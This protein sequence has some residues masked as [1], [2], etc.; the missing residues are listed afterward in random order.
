[1]T[2][3]HHPLYAQEFDLV[4]RGQ[5]W[6]EDRAWFHDRTGRLRS[7]PAT[8]TDLVAE[9]PFNVV[10]D[11]RVRYFSHG[12]VVTGRMRPRGPRLRMTR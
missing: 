12:M 7:L 9:E 4:M 1:M 5:N 11:G 6:R 8:W 2:H 10:A 3:P